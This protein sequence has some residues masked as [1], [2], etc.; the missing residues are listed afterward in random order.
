MR[1]NNTRMD[2]LNMHIDYAYRIHARHR[3]S[4]GRIDV[5]VL[6]KRFKEQK[7]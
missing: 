1:S 2:L 6:R 4:F 7:S 3:G 5:S